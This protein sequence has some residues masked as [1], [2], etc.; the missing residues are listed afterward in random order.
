V[1]ACFVTYFVM[2]APK[3]ATSTILEAY[4]VSG[5][6]ALEVYAGLAK[7]GVEAFPAPAP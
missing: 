4:A 2:R 5:D 1:W 3:D 7:A 6:P